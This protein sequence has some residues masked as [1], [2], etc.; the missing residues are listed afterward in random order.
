[1]PSTTSQL[2]DF[3]DEHRSFVVERHEIASAAFADLRF[4]VRSIV[5]SLSQSDD[6]DAS[7]II[8]RM[9]TVLSTWLTTPVRFDDTMSR[10]LQEM[11]TPA[12]VEARWGRDVRAHYE[13]SLA[14]ADTLLTVENPL[15]V[16]LAELVRDS[17]STG[18]SFRIFCHRNARDHFESLHTDYE[19][20]PLVQNLFVHSVAHL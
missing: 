20:M 13:E 4:G 5:T 18:T 12:G 1:M 19:H 2:F 10:A 8:G 16:K 9:R 11:G 6:L 17:S 15:R 14:S 7:E 3:L